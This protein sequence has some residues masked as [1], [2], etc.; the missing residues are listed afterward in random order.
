MNAAGS[1]NLELRSRYKIAAQLSVH[2]ADSNVDLRV[3]LAGFADYQS[4]A[5]GQQLAR[6]LAIDLKPISERDVACDFDSSTYP[7]EIRIVS[8]TLN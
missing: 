5:L 2:Y 3:E 6:N 8:L 4:S 7:P 1:A